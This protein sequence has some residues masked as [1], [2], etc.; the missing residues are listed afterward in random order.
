M[1]PRVVIVDNVLEMLWGRPMY[2]QLEAPSGGH[3][4]E[5]VWELTGAVLNDIGMATRVVRVINHSHAAQ[6][7]K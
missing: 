3:Y 1:D 7:R 2:C 6:I 4:P 5:V